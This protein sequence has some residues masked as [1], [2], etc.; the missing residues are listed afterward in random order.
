M[1]FKVIRKSDGAIL[2]ATS[3]VIDSDGVPDYVWEFSTPYK[4]N[5][6]TISCED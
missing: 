6:V 4:A 3:I 5:R 2:H 1:K